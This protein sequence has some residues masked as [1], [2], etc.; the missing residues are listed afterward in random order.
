M[1][2]TLLV[3]GLSALSAASL[4]LTGG[5]TASASVSH[6]ARRHVS[7]DVDV[8]SGVFDS[9][10]KAERHVAALHRAGFRGFHVEA[11]KAACKTSA[12]CAI[13]SRFAVESRS[14]SSPS[15]ART[16]VHEL[17]R[18]GFHA[19]VFANGRLS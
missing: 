5:G 11:R 12:H 4:G 1:R 9:H 13:R 3:M 15:V 6:H 17:E 7:H 14:V 19:Q 2:R 16:K 10:V 18:R 8:V